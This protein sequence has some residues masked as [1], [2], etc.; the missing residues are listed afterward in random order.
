MKIYINDEEQDLGG[1]TL[2]I[3]QLLDHFKFENTNGMAIAVNDEVI[4]RA[5][6]ENFLLK[7]NDH[8]LLIKAAQGG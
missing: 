2:S 8:I 5:N 1:N 3:N 4:S 6:W 7:E